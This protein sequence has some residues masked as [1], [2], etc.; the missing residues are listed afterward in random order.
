MFSGTYLCPDCI[1]PDG[2]FRRGG[3]M[4]GDGD[5]VFCVVDDS[6]GW[7]G[8]ISNVDASVFCMSFVVVLV[9][10]AFLFLSEI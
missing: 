9:A 7:A 5:V 1:I 4:L 3:R 8:I 10:F 6:W 2:M